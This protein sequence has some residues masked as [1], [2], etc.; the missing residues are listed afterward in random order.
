[1]PLP[2]FL[3]DIATKGSQLKDRIFGRIREQDTEEEI[4]QKAILDS[5]LQT[6]DSQTLEEI[7]ASLQENVESMRE[8]VPESERFQ[9]KQKTKSF[10]G[11]TMGRNVDQRAARLRE[12][13][14]KS[15]R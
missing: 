3:T 10:T 1:M 14:K 9:S 12:A 15:K 4:R 6:A 11:A 5:L 2:Q 13:L 7:R 8:A